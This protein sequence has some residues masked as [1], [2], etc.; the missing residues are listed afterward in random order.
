M[1]IESKL[2]D[3]AP[4][5]LLAWSGSTMGTRAIHVSRSTA[6]DGG[7]WAVTEES[8]EGF[9]AWLLR[10]PLRRML[11]GS[12]ERGLNALKSESERRMR[13]STGRVEE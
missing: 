1:P 4:P 7:T 9:L 13:T 8:F 2:L 12:L 10:G 3:V 11:A 5:A 6:R